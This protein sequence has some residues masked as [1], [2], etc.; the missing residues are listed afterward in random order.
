MKIL[1]QNEHYPDRLKGGGGTTRT[2]YV[3]QLLQRLGHQP[4]ILAKGP[5]GLP[6]TEEKVNGVPVIKLSS[7]R[8]PTR[9]WP[10]WPFL[11]A[12]Y[13]RAAMESIGQPFDAC[14]FEDSAYGLSFKR[15]FPHRPLIC[16]VEGTRKSYVASV[17]ENNGPARTFAERK[18]A[19]L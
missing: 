12:H 1:W 16:R 10:L 7:P 6:A 13:L 19:A 15:V 8:M 2:S 17:P 14:F 4:V 3:T 18:R 9:L 11:E 5:A